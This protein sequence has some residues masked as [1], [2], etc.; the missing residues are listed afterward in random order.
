[1]KVGT[2]GWCAA[3]L[4]AVVSGGATVAADRHTY[5]D[6]NGNGTLNDCPNPAHNAKGTSNT[7]ELQYCNGGSQIGTV[8]GTV[9]GTTTATACTSGGGAVANVTSGLQVDVDRDGTRESVYGQPQACVWNMA[10]SDTCEIHAGTYRKPGFWADADA[11]SGGMSGNGSGCDKPNCSIGLLAALGYGPNLTGSG[12]GTSVSPGY[13]RGA[14]MNGS[15]DSWDANN[16]K[17]PDVDEGLPSYAVVFNGDLNANGTFEAT[18]CTDASCATDGTSGD[19]FYAIVLGC[20][21]GSYDMCSSSHTD[22]YHVDSDANGSYDQIPLS[23]KKSV[24]Y[25]TIRDIEVTRFNGGHTDPSG[26]GVRAREGRIALEGDG[27][28]SGIVVDH[29]YVHDNDYSL[30]TSDENWWSDFSDSHN[31][32]CATWTEIKRSLLVQSNEKIFDDDC[33]T[34]N[35]CGCPK[36]IHDNRMIV[37]ITSSRASGR[38]PVIA[39]FK[40]IDTAGGGAR[41]KAHRFWNNEIIYERGAGSRF[42]DLQAFG[43]SLNAGQGELWFYGN[44]VRN[45]ASVV[46]NAQR[47]WY[48]FCGIGTGNYRL[49][50]FNNTF[51]ITYTSNS[52]GIYVV[53]TDAGEK[54]VEKN[55]AYWNGSTAIGTHQSTATSIT[56]ANEFCS[57]TDTACTKPTLTARTDWFTYTTP[58]FYSGLSAYAAKAGGPLVGV[59]TNNACDPDAD[60]TAG[61]DYN[62]DG[63]NDTSWTDIAGKT[64]SCPTAATPIAVG[65]IQPGSSGQPDTTPPAN[66]LG[67]K[68]SDKH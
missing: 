21:G 42:M 16:N 35:E 29:V 53:C 17:Q 67:L 58:T 59:S 34:G 41:I 46:S 43:T 64:V 65:A 37:N 3:V 60:G 45:D 18:S 61:V 23:G 56:R 33:G 13:V 11:F 57:A 9:A 52:D 4:F 7:E 28:S 36:N 68:R 2:L 66:V 32:S 62:W 39:Y 63:V 47:W 26:A 49:Y 25:L 40:S 6:T 20:N 8:I 1:M 24:A 54:I 22:G 55:N 50:F 38:N 51:D 19:A 5:L 31:A 10:K 44:L 15:I 30:K 48:S 14:V 27:A 12:Y